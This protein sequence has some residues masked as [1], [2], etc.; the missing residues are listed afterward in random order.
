MP[1]PAIPEKIIHKTIFFFFLTLS[2]FF[3]VCSHPALAQAAPLASTSPSEDRLS[4][5]PKVY[6]RLFKLEGNTVFSEQELSEIIAPYE[7]REITSEELQDLR[8]KLTQF[9]VDKGYINSGVI[10]P[11]QKFTDGTL[12]LRVIEGNLSAIEI[13]G[14]K[15]FR[16]SYLEK[17]LKLGAGPPLNIFDLRESLLIL[18][19][20]PRIDRINAKLSP[21]TEKDESV[22]K[23]KVEE[24][25]PYT[26]GAEVGNVVSPAIGGV[27]GGMHFIHDNLTGNGD[28]LAADIGVTT[29]GLADWLWVHHTT[30]R[31]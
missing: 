28:I 26:I 24:E 12:V 10:I 9:Y 13:S 4:T 14:N 1:I 22:L 20:D 21:G 29:N 31:P 27:R 25:L 5:M 16:D 6:V 18:Q 8:R 23:V 11:D 7:N 19:Q 15:Y 17:R 3:S 2:L 30:H